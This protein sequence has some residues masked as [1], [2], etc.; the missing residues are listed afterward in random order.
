MS[1]AEGLKRLAARLQTDADAVLAEAEQTEYFQPTLEVVANAVKALEDFADIIGEAGVG[2]LTP[3]KLEELAAVAQAFDESGDELLRKQA[4]VLDEILLT[5]GTPQG[6]VA[7][8]RA[9]AD[10][11]VEKLRARHRDERREDLYGRAKKELDGRN[12]KD[13]IV[14]AVKDQVKEYRPLESTL[15]TRYCPDHPGVGIV[16]IGDHVYQCS[17]DRKIYNWESGFTTMKGNKI[18]GGGVQYQTHDDGQRGGG[19]YTSFNT[20]ESLLSRYASDNEGVDV[21]LEKL[22]DAAVAVKSNSENFDKYIESNYKRFHDDMLLTYYS[23]M[24]NAYIMSPDS[25]SEFVHIL[26][27]DGFNVVYHD[28]SNKLSQAS[29]KKKAE[30]NLTLDLTEEEINGLAYAA[31]RYDSAQILWDNWDSDA[32]TIPADAVRE[33]YWATKGDGGNLGTVPLIGGTLANKISDL[34]AAIELGDDPSESSFGTVENEISL[35]QIKEKYP[36]AYEK[37][38]DVEIFDPDMPNGGLTY[39]EDVN[40]N[41]CLEMWRHVE[42]DKEYREEYCWDPE[43]QRWYETDPDLRQ[44]GPRDLQE[45]SS[46]PDVG[47]FAGDILGV[48]VKPYSQKVKEHIENEYLSGDYDSKYNG[49]HV[50]PGDIIEWIDGLRADGF[51]IVDYRE[52]D[53]SSAADESVDVDRILS[54]AKFVDAK[55]RVN[56]FDATFELPVGGFI[57][58][59]LRASGKWVLFESDDSEGLHANRVGNILASGT[60][61]TAPERVKEWIGSFMKDR[62]TLLKYYGS[63][64]K[65]DE[66]NEADDSKPYVPYKNVEDDIFVARLVEFLNRHDTGIG[67]LPTVKELLEDGRLVVRVGVSGPGE[68]EYKIEEEVIEPTIQAARDWLGY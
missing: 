49:F 8:L 13:E 43:G 61:D 50:E 41:L 64:E 14:K 32:K 60:F 42:G 19:Y 37:L 57:N 20:R 9:K 30:E 68:D 16:R 36:E 18:R 48:L 59:T 23:N 7:G 35:E 52:V 65:S 33:A 15:S 3:D 28:Q 44:D 10:E 45:Q 58:L 17:L 40:G 12:K 63:D 51:N 1:I 24:F 56:K 31:D 26:Q 66:L 67:E 54:S 53:K 4:S 55:G 46:L 47:I 29:L 34:F 21:I 38:S 39:F 6:A 5:I 25:V 22:N 62:E 2:V 27:N 11:E